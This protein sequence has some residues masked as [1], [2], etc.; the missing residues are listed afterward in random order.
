MT[1]EEAVNQLLAYG[2]PKPPPELY[3]GGTGNMGYAEPAAAPPPP[4]S[5]PTYQQ[6]EAAPAPPPPSEPTSQHYEELAFQPPPP[7]PM[8]F[9]S[10]QPPALVY[11]TGGANPEEGVPVEQ[12]RSMPP[13]PPQWSP[14][15]LHFEDGSGEVVN[16]PNDRPGR[17]FIGDGWLTP[18]LDGPLD[19][20]QA[21][22]VSNEAMRRLLGGLWGGRE[23]QPAPIQ[24]WPPSRIGS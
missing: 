8:A 14:Q 19:P 1:D 9:Q 20:R 5:E 7:S 18:P 3:A 21:R 16:D 22:P 15:I 24:P 10:H 23:Q 12:A 11:P 4:P 2:A 6:Y 17:P 13:P